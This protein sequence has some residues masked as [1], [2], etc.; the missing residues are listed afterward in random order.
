M[1]TSNNTDKVKKMNNSLNLDQDRLERIIELKAAFM[2]EE[3]SEQEARKRAADFGHIT[4]EEFAFAEQNL[5]LHGVDD[6][7]LEEKLEDL[8]D[9]FK[10]VLDNTFPDLPVGHP[11]HTYL[12]ENKKIREL[13]FNMEDMLS[14]K[15]IINP[16]LEIYEKLLTIETHYDR[17]QN[18]IFPYLERKG[19]DKP[20]SVMWTLDNQIKKNIKSNYADLKSDTIIEETNTIHFLKSQLDLIKDLRDMIFKEEQ[21]LYP[22]ALEMLTEKEFILIRKGDDEIGYCLIDPPKPWGLDSY[23]VPPMSSANESGLINLGQGLLTVE[24]INLIF[25]HLPV[26]VSFVDENE[27]VRFYNDIPHRIFPRSPGVIGRE[28]QNCHPRESVG[29]VMRIIEAFKTGKKD[30]A[31]FWLEIA[32]KFLHIQYFAVK[33]EQGEFKGILEMMQDATHVR[34]L[35]GSNR[36]LNWDDEAEEEQHSTT[37]S[38]DPTTDYTR[39]VGDLILSG[40]TKLQDI[41]DI[42]PTIKPFLINFNPKFK[43]LKNDMLFKMMSKIADLNG[44]SKRG[45]ISLKSLIDGIAEE[46]EKGR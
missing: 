11:I 16:W 36:L 35:E 23:Q 46:M 25:K 32:G 8:I 28:V 2:K 41:L 4:P 31:E 20:T 15:F 27:I 19:F 21:I 12:E 3:I 42:D 17:K 40:D 18:Q 1:N 24:Q 33:N 14:D 10:D 45:Q 37:E 44:I 5:V 7:M 13:T 22:T 30:T 6:A 26:D 43:N 9:V 29:T 34:R 38:N 39:Q